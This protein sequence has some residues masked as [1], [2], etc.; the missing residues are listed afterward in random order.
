MK[1][2]VRRQSSPPSADETSP[3][4]STALEAPLAANRLAMSFPPK[5]TGNQSSHIVGPATAGDAQ[6]LEQYMSPVDNAVVR[7]NPYSVYSHDP[8]DPVVYTKVPRQRNIIPSGNGTAGFKQYEV[9][10]KIVDPLGPELFR[11]CVWP[12]QTLAL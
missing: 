5:E 1:K 2:D 11:M 6:V 7:P 9:M 3:Q 10:E 8:R 12:S 4:S